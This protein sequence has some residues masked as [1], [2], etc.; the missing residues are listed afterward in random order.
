MAF[1]PDTERGVLKQML[2]SIEKS[3]NEKNFEPAFEHLHPD[4]VLIVQNGE[5]LKGIDAIQDFNK[6]MFDGQSAV[7]KDHSTTASEDEPA[8]FYG[9]LALAHGKVVDKFVFAGGKTVELTS[10]WTTTLIKEDDKWQVLSL[11][12]TSNVFDNPLLE[13]SKNSLKYFTL[14]AFVLGFLIGGFI[15]RRFKK[16]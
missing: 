15:L 13:A 7:L 14:I 5:T 4:V 12:F 8:E 10:K 16:S 2:I 6:R 3:I 11:Q 9:N 1:D